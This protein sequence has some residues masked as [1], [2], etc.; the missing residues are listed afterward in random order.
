MWLEAGGLL[1]ALHYEW[2]LA[3]RYRQAIF[4]L[5]ISQAWHGFGE[6]IVALLFL[7]LGIRRCPQA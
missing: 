1:D 7:Y 2:M 5:K 3:R 6:E 4:P